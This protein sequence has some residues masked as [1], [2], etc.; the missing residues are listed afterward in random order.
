MPDSAN[1]PYQKC[2]IKRE[3]T[4]ILRD[5]IERLPE[6]QRTPKLQHD[7]EIGFGEHN[8]IFRRYEDYFKRQTEQ[9]RIM[10][11]NQNSETHSDNDR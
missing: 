3:R 10:K 7:M 2:C 6:V 9:R 5:I 8:R 1:V 4:E 11:G